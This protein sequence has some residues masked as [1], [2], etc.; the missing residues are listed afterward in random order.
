MTITQKLKY[1]YNNIKNTHNEQDLQDLFTFT[2]D[3]INEIYE[4]L[5]ESNK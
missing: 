2:E 1:I 4:E 3:E 5:F